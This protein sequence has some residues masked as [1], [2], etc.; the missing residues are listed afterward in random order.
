MN[1][2][3]WNVITFNTPSQNKKTEENK[4]LHSNK[5]NN[6]PEKFRYEAPKKFGQLLMQARTSKNLNQKDISTLLG[7][8][9]N[10]YNKW[11]SNKELPTNAQIADIEKKL[12]I[13]LPRNKKVIAKEI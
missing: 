2:Q 9:L 11:E 6:D 1:H 8:S 3:D 12:N 7:I 4:K 13:K 5:I 10:I